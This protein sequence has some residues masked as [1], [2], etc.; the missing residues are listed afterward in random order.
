MGK[1]L[2]FIALCAA[3]LLTACAHPLT[4]LWRTMVTNPWGYH[5]KGG[6]Q[7]GHGVVSGVVRGGTGHRSPPTHG[8]LPMQI[9]N[10]PPPTN[11]PLPEDW[12]AHLYDDAPHAHQQSSP[13]GQPA[14]YRNTISYTITTVACIQC[15]TTVTLQ[16][17]DTIH[18]DDPRLCT[19]LR[20]P[21]PPAH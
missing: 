1:G 10:A 2:L 21:I 14:L 20:S 11:H 5:P 13:R 15:A 3:L 4:R 8:Y 18:A 17:G 12:R 6:Q 9:N 19:H 7:G 16:P